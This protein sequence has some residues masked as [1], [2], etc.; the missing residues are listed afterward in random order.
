MISDRYQCWTAL[1]ASPNDRNGEIS[2]TPRFSGVTALP[3]TTKTVLTV[4]QS[5]PRAF[6]R[7]T[8]MKTVKTVID[9]GLFAITPLKRGVNESP[10]PHLQIKNLRYVSNS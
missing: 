6:P 1:G 3:P 10:D 5:S 4:S 7:R 8:K 2:L 9:L